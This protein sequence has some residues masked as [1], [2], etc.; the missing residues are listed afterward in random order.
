[1]KE[2]VKLDHSKFAP[3]A[4]VNI[5]SGSQN[6][7]IVLTTGIGYAAIYGNGPF[8]IWFVY[9]Y[10]GA[11]ATIFNQSIDGGSF[12]PVQPGIYPQLSAQGSIVFQWQ[13]DQGQ[14]IKYVW[15]FLS[16]C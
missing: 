4:G 8:S 6:I 11:P 3:K 14:S 13:V 10:G 7:N 1:M 2:N 16:G 5:P 12:Q 9:E 15:V